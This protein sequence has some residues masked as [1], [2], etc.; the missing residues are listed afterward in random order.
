MFFDCLPRRFF[1]F[2]CFCM[3]SLCTIGGRTTPLSAMSATSLSRVWLAFCRQG[4]Q[5]RSP[6][7]MSRKCTGRPSLSKWGVGRSLSG[8]TSVM[9]P[10]VA[11]RSPSIL[12]S[13]QKL[14][15]RMHAPTNGAPVEAHSKR[16][17]K[18]TPLA[19]K[20]T[21]GALNGHAIGGLEVIEGIKIGIS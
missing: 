18:D 6:R 21:K 16:P 8:C 13:M 5:V 19:H 20:H 9:L 12:R 4:L 10:Y 14:C 3:P 1:C 2:F 7:S 11:S 15:S 17:P